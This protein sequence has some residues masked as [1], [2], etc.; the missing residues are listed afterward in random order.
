[1]GFPLEYGGAQDIH[2]EI[3]KIVPGYYHKNPGPLPVRLEGY[4]G[5]GYT[6]QTPLRYVLKTPVRP[7]GYP[8]TLVLGQILHHSGK[9]STRSEGLMKIYDRNRLQIG[10]ADAERLGISEGESVRLRSPLGETAVAIE[11]QPA[12]PP[13]L[14]FFPE[15][16]SRPPV[17]DLIAAELDP[18]TRVVY[19]KSGPVALEKSAAPAGGA[20]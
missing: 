7:E 10:P 2:R 9:F 12:L 8:F 20:P 19:H 4:L 15:H 14:L 5:N 3:A 16:F 13:G 1:M 6:Q 18:V 17:K 11:I